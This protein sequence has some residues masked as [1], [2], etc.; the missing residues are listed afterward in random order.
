MIQKMA[1]F[2]GLDLNIEST[3]RAVTAVLSAE[4][5]D[6]S[7]P[8]R[9]CAADVPSSADD[10]SSARGSLRWRAQGKSFVGGSALA[11]TRSPSAESFSASIPSAETNSR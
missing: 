1:F 10:V 5:L 4:S 8:T 7:R 6:A 9:V 2:L 3:P 11:A